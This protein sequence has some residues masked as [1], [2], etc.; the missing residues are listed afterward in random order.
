MLL[1]DV[2]CVGPRLCSARHRKCGALRRVRGTREHHPRFARSFSFC[3]MM[4]SRAVFQ[5][6]SVQSR[7][8]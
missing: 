6:S 4:L 1:R 3:A 7:S 5:S 2:E 8:W